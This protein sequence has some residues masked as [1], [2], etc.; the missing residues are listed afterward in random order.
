MLSIVDM[1]GARDAEGG[2]VPLLIQPT[3]SAYQNAFHLM[4]NPVVESLV[5]T[6]RAQDSNPG[7]FQKRAVPTSD[8]SVRIDTLLGEMGGEHE[9]KVQFHGAIIPGGETIFRDGE[10]VQGSDSLEQA[11]LVNVRSAY[12]QVW[13]CFSKIPEDDE[14]LKSPEM[15]D[16]LGFYSTKSA[17]KVQR[18]L[19]KLNPE[20]FKDYKRLHSMERSIYYIIDASPLYFVFYAQN[21]GEGIN[22]LQQDTLLESKGKFSIA[23]VGFEGSIERLLKSEPI[24]QYIISQLQLK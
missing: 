22:R 1:S 13:E 3:E 12:R 2:R 21:P 14:F 8:S 5:A 15:A 10:Y 23:N 7:L 17:G 19:E 16:Y 11:E 6:L 20:D 9:V 24:Q 4:T 18:M